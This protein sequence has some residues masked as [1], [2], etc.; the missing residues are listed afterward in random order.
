MNDSIS[1]LCLLVSND[2]IPSFEAIFKLFYTKLLQFGEAIVKNREEAE[3]IVE[4]VFIKL[5]SNRKTL[6]AVKNLNYY[7]FVSVKHGA[8]N[9]LEKAKRNAVLDIDTALI[10]LGATSMNPEESMI[11]FETMQ[12]IQAAIDTLPPKCKLIFK[13]IKEDGLKYK[14]A[15]NLLNISVKTIEAQMS[16]A[17]AKVGQSLQITTKDDY[18]NLLQEKIR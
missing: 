5:W 12:K 1:N 8:L 17:I 3:E 7:L 2:D 18:T 16:I 15:A 11:S 4:D 13:L 10:D 6:P 14:E 9:Y